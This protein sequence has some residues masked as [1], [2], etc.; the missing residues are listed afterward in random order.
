MPFFFVLV[1]LLLALSSATVAAADGPRF[2]MD[3]RFEDWKGVGPAQKVDGVGELQAAALPGVLYLSFELDR[4][5]NL[6]RLDAPLRIA[7]DADGSAL[8]PPGVPVDLQEQGG[9]GHFARSIVKVTSPDRY[10]LVAGDF[11]L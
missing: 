11:F 4:V 6:D 5:R 8:P 7:I 3:G 2:V 1:G 10:G 9:D